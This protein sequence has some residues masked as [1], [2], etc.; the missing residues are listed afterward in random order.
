MD[1]MKLLRM[2]PMIAAILLAGLFV[3]GVAAW[4]LL[5]WFFQSNMR[6]MSMGDVEIHERLRFGPKGVGYIRIERPSDWGL[7]LRIDGEDIMFD[8][9]MDWDLIRMVADRIST[10][11]GSAWRRGTETI[12]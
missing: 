11:L 6:I 7:V 8:E 12:V 5:L 3:L 4:L 10:P 9:P 2:L 1:P